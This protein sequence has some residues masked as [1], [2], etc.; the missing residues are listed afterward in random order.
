M[1]NKSVQVD[2]LNPNLKN[3]LCVSA[4]NKIYRQ[5]VMLKVRFSL[6]T[7]IIIWFFLNLIVLAAILFAFFSLNFRYRPN[8]GFSGL[9]GNTIEVVTRQITNELDDK[10]RQERDEIL[11]SYSEKHAGVEFFLFDY[12]GEQIG[13]RQITLPQEVF[14]KMTEPESFPPPRPSQ[15]QFSES[16]ER[17][18]PPPGMMP[19]APPSMYLRT[20][21]PTNYWYGAKSMTF[22]ENSREPVRTRLIAVSDSFYGYGLFFNPLPWIVLTAIIILVSILFWFPFVRRL[23]KNIESLTAASEKIAD[24]DFTVRVGERRSDELGRLGSAI[25]HLA[26]RLSGFIGGQKRFL[27]DISHELN[28]PLARMNFALQILE[29]RVGG[30]NRAYVED[31]KEE[32][33]IMTKLVGELLSYSKTGI[34]SAEVTTEK[35]LLKPLVEKVV[36]RETTNENAEI[37]SEIDKNISV[38]AQPELLSRAIGNIIRNAVSYAGNAGEISI[39]A[40]KTN[41]DLIE[42]TIAD[43]GAGVPEDALTQIFDPL[44]RVNKDRARASGGSGLG[45][46]IVKTCVEACGGRV[47]AKNLA[48]KGFAVKILLKS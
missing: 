21:N 45:L 16:G 43:K 37:K 48:P 10:T 44:F 31:V 36:M 11:K 24:E 1:N 27:G 18:E 13:G 46:A 33:E 23:T 40:E 7:K 17:R 9:F 5:I 8:S 26:E 32:V 28:S 6:F 25:N 30:E 34:K 42:I 39:S 38:L 3:L 35:V 20:T 2:K 15:R 22:L 29:D 14:D 41:N 19:P 12:K 4:V 47:Y